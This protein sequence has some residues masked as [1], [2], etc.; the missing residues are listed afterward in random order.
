M[1]DSSSSTATPMQA[2]TGFDH[3]DFDDIF[4]KYMKVHHAFMDTSNK[5]AFKKTIEVAAKGGDWQ[6]LTKAGIPYSTAQELI[7]AMKPSSG[8]LS[9]SKH[10]LRK[11][12]QMMPTG[13]ATASARITEE[14]NTNTKEDVEQEE[15][16]VGQE[17]SSPQSEETTQTVTFTKKTKKSRGVISKLVTASVGL[18]IAV[19]LLDEAVNSAFL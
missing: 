6:T 7:K 1:T 10:I 3:S 2:M 16:H 12:G 4:G 9:P 8:L 17:Q 13:K 18:P 19:T 5:E 11:E 14:E 15:N